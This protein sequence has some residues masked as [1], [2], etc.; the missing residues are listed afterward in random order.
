MVTLSVS[1]AIT[2]SFENHIDERLNWL[3]IVL[4][5]IN[6]KVSMPIRRS[7]ILY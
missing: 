1:A 4:Q 5:N 3:A 6:L 2:S 7:I